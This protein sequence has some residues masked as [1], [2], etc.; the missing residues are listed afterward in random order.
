MVLGGKNEGRDPPHYTTSLQF[1]DPTRLRPEQ[2]LLMESEQGNTQQGNTHKLEFS[3]WPSSGLGFL[4]GTSWNEKH[5]CIMW[6]DPLQINHPTQSCGKN[7]VSIY[8]PWSTRKEKH[9]LSLFCPLPLLGQR[10]FSHPS[11]PTDQT[12]ASSKMDALTTKSGLCALPIWPQSTLTST[13][14]LL[15]SFRLASNL[16]RELNEGRTKR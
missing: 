15:T 7:Q 2:W 9:L 12:I 11:K 4:V 13:T 10:S 14:E 5:Q 6:S 8:T 16:Q 3:C 1:A